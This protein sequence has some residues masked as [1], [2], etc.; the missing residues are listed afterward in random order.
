MKISLSD[1][2]IIDILC[3]NKG[4]KCLDDWAPRTQKG[5]F[6]AHCH[7]YHKHLLFSTFEPVLFFFKP[8]KCLQIT[9]SHQ[10]LSCSSNIVEQ[11]NVCLEALRVRQY[12]SGWNQWVS[13][14]GKHSLVHLLAIS[15]LA[16]LVAA[17]ELIEY[18]PLLKFCHV[19]ATL[20]SFDVYVVGVYRV[21][22]VRRDGC[23]R[24]EYMYICVWAVRDRQGKKT[25]WIGLA[26]YTATDFMNEHPILSPLVDV[27]DGREKTRLGRTEGRFARVFHAN[28][29]NESSLFNFD[30]YLNFGNLGYAHMSVSIHMDHTC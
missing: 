27:Y 14:R 11:F 21:C 26:S 18:S 5:Y 23:G 4:N 16:F 29:K 13:R 8:L 24:S 1:G 6:G 15:T 2:Y 30:V 25:F 28:A 22:N 12:I 9:V 3:I 19:A 17:P 20:A 10:N 7:F